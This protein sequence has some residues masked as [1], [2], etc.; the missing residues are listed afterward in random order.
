MTKAY[1]K[2]FQVQYMHMQSRKID[3]H[4]IIHLTT[5]D[6]NKYNTPKYHYVV[7]FTN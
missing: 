3:Y 2:R 6:K 5:Q 1:F 7:K 4:V